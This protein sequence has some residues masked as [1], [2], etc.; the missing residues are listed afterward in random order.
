[1]P[2]K[3]A[4]LPLRVTTVPALALYVSGF[5]DTFYRLKS[6]V[7]KLPLEQGASVT[8]HVVPLPMELTLVGIAELGDTSAFQALWRLW[9]EAEPM[10]VF[11]RWAFH[12]EMLIED[13]EPHERGP[14]GMRFTMKLVQIRRVGVTPTSI[15]TSTTAEGAADRTDELARGFVAPEDLELYDTGAIGPEELASR[16]IDEV[17]S[18]V[19]TTNV[20]RN[21]PTTIPDAFRG[22]NPPAVKGMA[23]TTKDLPGGAR[24]TAVTIRWNSIPGVEEYELRWEAGKPGDDVELFGENQW[25][26]VDTYK[27]AIFEVATI[28][29][30]RN[31]VYR[32]YVRGKDGTA[33][34]ASLTWLRGHGVV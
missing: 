11:T 24:R 25:R 22:L 13:I 8:D 33:T 28:R 26:P 5:P 27:D 9:Q 16:Y 29:V 7:S 14:Y 1:M 31:D 20:A 18:T 6:H 17:L 21:D 4:L 23:V 30:P 3:V 12:Q 15:N 2:F 32:F 19:H 10:S 34:E